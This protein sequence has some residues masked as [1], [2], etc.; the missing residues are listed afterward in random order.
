MLSSCGVET[1]LAGGCG[2][3]GNGTGRRRSREKPDGGRTED[4]RRPFAG[5][6]RKAGALSTAF[7]DAERRSR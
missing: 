1:A 4:E 7:R 6:R 3:H 5:C 2:G